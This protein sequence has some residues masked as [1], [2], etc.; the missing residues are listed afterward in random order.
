MIMQNKANQSETPFVK[1]LPLFIVIGILVIG[2]IVVMGIW[3]G[4]NK[5][6]RMTIGDNVPDFTM[7]SFQAENF[8]SSEMRGKIVII[9]FWASWCNTCDAE[10][11]MLQEIWEEMGSSGD[12]LIVG[13]DYVDTDKAAQEFIDSHGITYPNF[14]D[15]GSK[16]SDLFGIS[17]VPETFLIDQNGVIKAIEIGPF[18]STDDLRNFIAQ[19]AGQ[20]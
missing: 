9:N 5:V 10:S 11:Y 18:T 6:D 3:M 14:P 7:T 1:N 17:G 15:L 12:F 20:E 13:V 8:D 2:L 4:N 19:A 16:I